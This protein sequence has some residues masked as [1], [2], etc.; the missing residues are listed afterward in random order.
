MSYTSSTRHCRR[1]CG[2]C[3][4]SL[5]DHR[6]FRSPP[7]YNGPESLVLVILNPVQD[8]RARAG[9]P[10]AGAAS[11]LGTSARSSRSPTCC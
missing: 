7:R 11:P 1:Y 9:N 5:L 3:L 10:E 8:L 4:E 6:N 2:A